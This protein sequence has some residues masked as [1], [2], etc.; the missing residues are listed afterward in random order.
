MARKG[1]PSV[2]SNPYLPFFA[3]L[4]A[5]CYFRFFLKSGNPEPSDKRAFSPSNRDFS[6]VIQAWAAVKNPLELSR[7]RSRAGQMEER[8]L[9][10]ANSPAAPALLRWPKQQ[11]RLG[12][13][14]GP[15]IAEEE[16]M[17]GQGTF[18]LFNAAQMAIVRSMFG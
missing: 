7:P 13:P 2:S 6:D 1:G 17:V 18:G 12:P 16:D 8:K 3:A 15:P 11:W 14:R 10:T 9:T 4:A 5:Q